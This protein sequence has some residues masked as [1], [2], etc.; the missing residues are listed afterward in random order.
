MLAGCLLGVGFTAYLTA[1]THT[2]VANASFLVATT[3]L[4][5]ALLARF[6]LGEAVARR[7]WFVLALALAGVAAM[8]V[9]GF[10]LG[11]WFGNLAA[12]TTAFCQACYTVALR[13]GRAVDMT[14]AVCLGSLVA[15]VL[16]GVLVRDFAVSNR[17]LAVCMM[18]ALV[19]TALGNVLFVVATRYLGAA[20]LSLLCLS[21][22]VMSPL[23]VW[24]AF[25]ERPSDWALAGGMV[26]LAA[27]LV[28][29]VGQ[30]RPATRGGR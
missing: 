4:L 19:S 27:V 13:R 22:V 10:A 6:V 17:D 16:G 1:I 9:E 28:H 12:L 29:V 11:G 3:P 21:E 5:S 14:P 8:A 18:V 26:V 15:T 20:E 7:T 2:T 25:A 30:A 23:W 24:F